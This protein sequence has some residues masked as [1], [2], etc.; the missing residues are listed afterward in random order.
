MSEVTEKNFGLIVAYMLPGFVS[1]WGVSHFS[2]TVDAWIS[3]SKAGGPSVGGF[4]YVTLGSLAL[5]MTVSAIRW[6]VIDTIHHLTGVRRPACDF[7]NLEERLQGFLTLVEHHYRYYQHYANTLVACALAYACVAA[8]GHLNPFEVSVS[9]VS[10][11]LLE[12]VLFLSSRNALCRYYTRVEGLL[13][14]SCS[15][16]QKGARPMTNGSGMPHE[17]T[18]KP[19]PKPEKKGSSGILVA[20]AL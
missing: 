17:E 5:G 15:Y 12:A 7:A 10:F 6:M 3:T 13:G 16:S 2:P 11:V 8:A 14:S 4:L 18:P 20:G 19:K 1:L 9:N